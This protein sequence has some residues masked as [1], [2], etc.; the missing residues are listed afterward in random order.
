ME[1]LRKA[2]DLARQE[3]ASRTLLGAAGAIERPLRARVAAVEAVARA[4][5]PAPVPA[6]LPA[7]AEAL[8]PEP[9]PALPPVPALALAPAPAAAP[10]ALPAAPEALS[11]APAPPA[12][13][14]KPAPLAPR[15]FVVATG[16][17][18][19]NRIV[20]LDPGAPAAE[21]FRR[22]RTQVVQRM[23]E[24][25]WRSL[26]LVSPGP[27]VGRTTAGINLAM[28][29]ATGS[30][31]S[32][33][34]VDLD[35]RS[36]ALGA[37]LGLTANHGVEDVLTGKE[38]LERCL[39]RPH[40]VDRL[41]ALPARCGMPT[42]PAYLAGP[43]ARALVAELRARDPDCFIIYD[44]PPVLAF[45]DALAFSPLVDCALLVVAEGLTRRDDVVRCL[46]LLSKVPVVGTV[47]NRAHAPA[48]P[49]AR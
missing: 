11:P 48:R 22:L 16:H 19:R 15:R 30:P 32:V 26:A 34:L 36:P 38:P 8:T 45:D 13:E 2:L 42:T 44:L 1:K 6:A 23:S 3:R 21:A 29:L 28:A 47:L 25:N 5:L 4:P 18:E 35:L 24:R 9:T 10:T 49:G 7:A 31:H 14:P 27:D 12:T 40:G 37:I 46:E 41:T 17:W 33:L 43:A 39:Y 20:A